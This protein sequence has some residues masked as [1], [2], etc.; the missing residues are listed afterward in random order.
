MVDKD[1]VTF[2][3]YHVVCLID[4][5]GQKQKLDKWKMPPESGKL[6]PEFITA[7]KDTAGAVLGYRE[8]FRTFFTQFASVPIHEKFKALPREL[9][10]KYR[11]AKDCRVVVER[12]SDTLVFSASIASIEGDA[13][14]GAVYPVLGACCMAMLVS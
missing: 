6:T 8:H 10:E 5:L 7:L 3:G 11:R 9:M 2:F 13:L 12:H 4:V 1:E 14:V